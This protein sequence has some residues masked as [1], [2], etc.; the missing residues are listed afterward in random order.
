MR[1]L[2]FLLVVII[3]SN[4]NAQFQ[5]M[6]RTLNWTPVEQ[7]MMFGEQVDYLYFKK[8]AYD[9][10]E[11]LIPGYYETIKLDQTEKKKVILRDQVFKALNMDE[12][13]NV[14]HLNEIPGEISVEARLTYVRRKPHLEISFTPLRRNP[15]SGALEILTGF[16]IEIIP[17][18]QLKSMGAAGFNHSYTAHSV[19]RNGPWFKV[20]VNQDGIY[21]LSYDELLDLGI[22][23]PSAVR[24]YGTN[25]SQL[26][27]QNNQ[28]QQ[29]DLKEI[30][31]WFETGQDDQFNQGDFLLFYGHGP[32]RWSYD[33]INDSYRH[34]VHKFSAWNYYFITEGTGSAKTIISRDEVTE[35][36][37]Y[38]TES[39]D[40]YLHHESNDINLIK[41]GSE[42]Y[43]EHFDIYTSQ[44]FTFEVPDLVQT[45]TISAKV[46]VLARASDTTSF[47]VSANDAYQG[48]LKLS[49]TNL[50]H[51]TSI[52]AFARTGTFD[53]LST[54]ND[55]TLTLEYRKN[56]AS[57]EGWLDFITLSARR[58]LNMISDQ[59]SFRDA[60]STGQNSITEFRISGAMSQ[61]V[62]WDITDHHNIMQVPASM[63]G[64]RLTFKIETSNMKEIVAFNPTGSFP[65]P[66]W[67]GEDV[68]RM[69]NQDLH[70]RE[71]VDYIIISHPDFLQ[72]ARR[73]AAFHYD[74]DNLD[75]IV[76]TPQKIYNEFSGGKPDVSA[77]RNFV[78]MFYD[79]ASG[80]NDMA[81][82]LLL[83]GDGSYDNYSSNEANSN[84]IL[85]YQSDNSLSPVGSYVTD[86]FFGLLDDTEGGASGSVDIG[87]GRFPVSSVNGA[88]EMINKVFS[89]TQPDKMGDWRNTLCF[90]GDDEDFNIHMRQADELAGYVSTN[91]PNFVISKIYLDAY[92]QISSST[93]DTYP[94][95]NEAINQRVN[96]GALIINYTG[97]GGENGLAHER[98]L[99][100]NDIINWEN[101][102]KLPLFM[103]ATCEFS[104]FD[105]YEHTS[106][107]ELVLLNPD[108]GGIALL[109]TTRLVYSGPNHTLN[110][111]FYE[112]VFERNDDNNY[113]R[114]GDIIRLTKVFSGTGFNKRNFT[115]LGD[116]A[117]VLSYPKQ[118]ISATT[119]NGQPIDAVT[120]TLK[121]LS[122][123]TISGRVTDEE[124]ELMTGFNGTLYPTVFDKQNLLK[125][126]GN[127]NDGESP[128]QFYIRNRI[129]Y[130]GKAS[131][132]DGEFSF[133]FIVPKD[134]SYNFGYGKI[135]FYGND[136][137][138]DASGYFSQIVVGGSADSIDSDTEGPEIELYMNDDNFV[139]GGTT[140]ENPEL[141][142]Y[143]NDSNGINTIG[144]GIGHDITAILDDNLN[145]PIVLNDYYESSTDSY[146]SGKITY[147]LRKLETGQH[148]LKVKVWDVYNN[149]SEQITEFTVV[150]SED[151]V[152]K[153]VLN[154]PNPFTTHTS[155]FFEHNHANS[156]LDVLIQVFTVSGKLVKSIQQEIPASGYRC[157][158]IDWD[159]LDD[160]GSRIGRGVYI[161]KVKVRSESGQVA[162]KFEKLV[163]L[164]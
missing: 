88:E 101:T 140:D 160:F 2:L 67:Q 86:D 79:R 130:K 147:P 6:R 48:R 59:L 153:H 146:Q 18:P 152:L 11:T 145:N 72:Q 97:H 110:E 111:K 58:S 39:Y 131:V 99:V 47:S 81:R 108:G 20:K 31:I 117:V 76:V 10:L 7:Q 22:V 92:Q 26:P 55:I 128:F 95:V 163:I 118:N 142:V 68:G 106:A 73:L 77:L 43:G 141:L 134:I 16:S 154:Y 159:G 119:V 138:Q 9:N 62:V 12:I 139:Y 56:A 70:G 122:K 137:E 65:S 93:G 75:T 40:Y 120:D 33:T 51:Y 50:S 14:R 115:L 103:T 148:K 151:L 96:K 149:S 61:T 133:S 80:E 17:A 37:D 30:P 41:S 132:N 162:E 114:L 45:E 32:N 150:S 156:S 46:A 3:T 113:Y 69:A 15:S 82:Y 158:P 85:T 21:K 123:V 121:A 104:R 107:G 157:G 1:Y 126:L 98:I 102:N 44:D 89:Y 52:H 74:Q 53:F 57:A 161:Y 35:S 155:F 136:S 60:R 23:Q 36:A 4:L 71:Q 63:S 90:I 38:I 54:S 100:I 13:K 144:S 87:I 42:W 25:G 112:F 8:A 78:K 83:F 5:G 28:P 125:T 19:L 129:L 34:Q 64:N 27:V 24:I 135:S 143:V 105:D 29:D 127:D 116:P 164:R 124:G 94:A 84:Y 109:T 91:Y 66:V 49:G